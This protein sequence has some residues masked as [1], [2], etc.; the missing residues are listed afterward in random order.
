MSI[1]II[2]MTPDRQ[3]LHDLEAAE[4]E[5]ERARGAWHFARQYM[6]SIAATECALGY[7]RACDDVAELRERYETLV[8][9]AVETE[10]L[11]EKLEELA[12]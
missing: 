12:L 9:D 2:D 6:D 5:A 11:R 4:R 1:R 3:A 8:M 7:A 10:R